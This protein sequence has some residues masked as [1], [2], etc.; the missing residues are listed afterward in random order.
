LTPAKIYW[1]S[2]S[3][4]DVN[5]EYTTNNGASW[6]TVQNNVPAQ[7][8][9]FDWTIP[10][11]GFTNQAKVRVMNSSNPA[12]GDTSDAVFRIILS[13]N[14]FSVLSP[15]NFT[16][17]ETNSSNTS[18]QQFVWGSTGSHPSLRYKF[19][20]RKIGAGG[21]D[22]IYNS[23]NNGIDTV[24][25][26]RKSFLDSLA[27]TI[28]TSGDS[29]LCT[30]RAWSYNGVDSA[31]TQNSLLVTFVRVTVGINIISSE[32]PERFNLENN[33]P[34]PFNPSTVIKFDVART[35]AISIT[36]YD[37]LGRQVENLVNEKLQPGKYEVS[38]NAANYSSGIYYY[39]MQTKEF[40]QTKKMLLVK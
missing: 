3:T 8:R 2:S 15:P 35:D 28:G 5:L 21:V 25:S 34:N 10:Y 37:M 12:E 24:V 19:K 29:V 39:R 23:D 16:R 13:Y 18:I 20:I 36:I 30:W 33:Y 26:F 14:T 11:I 22:R 1:G 40:V 6:I 7:Q 4:G 17:I 38:F 9:E 32:V 27:Q 31:A